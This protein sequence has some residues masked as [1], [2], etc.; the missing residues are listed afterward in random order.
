MKLAYGLEGLIQ[1]RKTSEDSLSHKTPTMRSKLSEIVCL[2]LAVPALLP[3]NA[4]AQSDSSAGQRHWEI[5]IDAGK[6]LL[7]NP[8][9]PGT[10]WVSEYTIRAGVGRSF[11][12]FITWHVFLEY[13]KYHSTIHWGDM[14]GPL[15]EKEYP[16]HDVA[17]YISFTAKGVFSLGL[18]AVS[19]FREDMYYRD[20][21]PGVS[22]TTRRLL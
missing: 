19:E 13:I 21:G 11:Q 7:Q 10:E 18:G 5:T 1:V 9:T 15:F 20:T 14:S 6:T 3:P 8:F 16:R 4:S 2:L 17:M 22:D 12:E